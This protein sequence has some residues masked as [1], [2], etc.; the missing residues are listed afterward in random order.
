MKQRT[1]QA[2]K[3]LIKQQSDGNLSILDFCKQQKIST[4]CFYK[5]KAI[6]QAKA[7]PKA[8]SFV[9]VERPLQT[10]TKLEP[11]K[12]QHGKTRIHLPAS[13]QPIW[14]ADFIKA[15]A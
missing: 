7:E 8:N 1:Q 10:T 9:K 2:W 12:L 4:S 5:H 15:L 6:N 13:I 11:I 3:Q 14:L